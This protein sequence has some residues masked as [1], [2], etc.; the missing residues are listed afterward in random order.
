LFQPARRFSLIDWIDR[1]HDRVEV[2]ERWRPTQLCAAIAD[3][4]RQVDE[5]LDVAGYNAPRVFDVPSMTLPEYETVLRLVARTAR[6]SGWIPVWLPQMSALIGGGDACVVA[7]RSLLLIVRPGDDVRLGVQ[8]LDRVD[9]CHGGSHLIL[10]L[11]PRSPGRPEGRR[12]QRD[13]SGRPPR[14]PARQPRTLARWGGPSGRPTIVRE[15]VARYGSPEVSVQATRADEARARWSLLLNELARSPSE[16][17]DSCRVQLAAVL[18]ERHQRFEAR[19]LL[20]SCQSGT[21]HL[22]PALDAVQM[23][24]DDL[25][26]R[27]AATALGR[28]LGSPQNQGECA[29]VD[30]FVGVLQLCQDIEDEHLALSRVGAFL[31]ERLQAATVA[32]IVRDGPSLRVLARAGADPPGMD[33][34]RQSI[35]SGCSVP[36]I[37]DRGPAESASPVRHAAEVIGALWCRWSAG[38]PIAVGDAR[39]L[40][41]VAAAASAPSMRAVVERQRPRSVPTDAVP[42]LVGES[43][44]IR[45]V[46]AA[47]LRA[48][49]SPFPVLIEG[50]SGSGKELVARAIHVCGSRRERRFCAINCAALVDDLVEAELFGHAKG[51][52]TGA[53]TERAGLFEEAGGGTL[54]LDE[55][56]ELGARVQAKLLRTLQEGE[57]RRI[58]EATVR[59]VDVRIVAA[60]NRPLAGEVSAGRFR[61]DLW[62]RLDVIRIAMP[63]LRDRIE[64]LPL[65]VRHLWA[66]LSERTGSRATLSPGAIAA[67]GAYDWPGNVREL[68]NVLASV[69]V[70]A[71]RRGVLGPSAW[72]A[73]VARVAALTPAT[74]LEAARRQFEERFVRAAMA[75]AGGRTSVAA[76]EL[77]ISRQG[78][79]KLLARLGIDSHGGPTPPN[80]VNPLE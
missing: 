22:R 6:G 52:F 62:Y 65:L 28:L 20:A 72:P 21:R 4:A 74:T 47:I 61:R 69:L 54:F 32:F 13:C 57:V 79:A 30:D 33:A 53:A 26:R 17:L 8:L 11:T 35:E 43:A 56:A 73:H 1:Q 64:D 70:A 25:R 3:V 45:A 71:P 31:R 24:L 58:G 42:E 67:L 63:P 77:G 19:A 48:A 50:E 80:A 38:T 15:A 14:S 18:A 16:R 78:L 29:M 34:A 51:A 40:L 75:R 23:R 7:G 39:S 41:G 37:G 44:S 60:T 2:W 66:S 68:Q 9:A 49:T 46:R 36:A 10:R 59:K 27:N 55:V 76:R 12:L 5:A